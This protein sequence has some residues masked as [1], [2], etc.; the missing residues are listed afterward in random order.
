MASRVVPGASVTIARSVP[1]SAL[2]N[3]DFPAL[4]RPAITASAP[5]RNRSP[6][7]AVR[8]NRRSESASRFK[9]ASM[10][11]DGTGPLSSSGKSIS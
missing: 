5:S 9:A 7:A 1:R 6:S 4:G 11:S 8:D 3:E 10:R 2:N